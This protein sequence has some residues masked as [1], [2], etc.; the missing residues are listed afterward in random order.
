MSV[1]ILAEHDNRI[2]KPVNLNVVTAARKLSDTI[3][4][5]V[6]G[7]DCKEVAQ[8][9]SEIEGINQVLLAQSE[10]LEHQ[11]AENV[12]PVVAKLAAD[13]DYVVTAATSQGKNVL[14]RAAAMVDIQPISDVIGVVNE[15]TFKR[16]IY[17]GNVIATVQS[18]DALKMLSIRAT[19]FE[20]AEMCSANVGVK[21]I[22]VN[23]TASV[24]LFKHDQLSQ[25]ERP[26]LTSARV[27][28]SGG[29]GM[30]NNQNFG[31]LYSLADSLEAAV[32]ASRAA[33][34]AGFAAND[35]QVGQTGKIVAPELY[36][37]FGI[38]GAIQH[39][40]GMQDSK[41]IVAINTDEEAPIMQIA[42][43]SLVADLF[44]V[45]PQLQQE[46]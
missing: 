21:E 38:S 24:S 42:D 25:S 41:V 19:A 37:A 27:V 46:L 30:Q 9:A 16:P 13:Y 10:T 4:I 20:K 8:H 29:R 2:L 1:L 3:D 32:G 11:L 39:L 28:I 17:A 34:D 12:A 15:S 6:V 43:Y 14:P 18:S 26:D 5:I 44:D 22:Q 35:L 45:I 33:V 40:A 23:E 36:I 31:L 7:H